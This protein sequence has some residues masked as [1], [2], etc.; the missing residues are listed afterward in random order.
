ML[1]KLQVKIRQIRTLA[2]LTPFDTGTEEGRSNERHRLILLSAVSSALAKV[3]SVATA[4]ISI[5]LTLHYLGT[6][7]F[8]LWMTISSVIA[9]L[10]FADLGIGNGLLNS[11]AEANGRDDIDA[12]KRYIS[13]AFAI[14]SAI[15]LA[16]LLVFFV[17]NPYVSWPGFFNV[18]SALASQEAD[19][20]VSIFML[21]FALN[22]PAGV[23]QR[24]QMALQ[25]SFVAN[26]WLIAG[27]LLGLVTVL[28]VIYFKLGL[29]WLVGGMFGAPILVAIL[30]S[31]FFFSK[32]RPD[33]RPQIGS[34]NR[35]AMNKVAHTGFL[36]LV[37]QVTVSLVFASDNIMISRILGAEAVTQFAIPD[38]LFS[39]IPV[40][41]GMIL[42]P[43]WPAYGEAISRGDGKWIKKIFV[44]S[45]ILALGFATIASL[46]FIVLGNSIL[47]AWVGHEVNAPIVLL[48]GMA[49][50]RIAEASG[51]SVSMLLNGANVV[52]FQVFS[53]LLLFIVAIPLKVYL[54]QNIGIAGAVMGTFVSYLLCVLI[55]Y[56]LLVPKILKRLAG[57]VIFPKII[58]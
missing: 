45:L 33:I 16:I 29:P 4:L 26:L 20:A 22:I 34:V 54:I 42:M 7:R 23:V 12:I 35:M 25:M 10:S 43:L 19:S 40:F 58:D 28:A 41:L 50:W 18:K 21:C 1:F 30:N 48:I 56:T 17:I 8:G 6:E 36:F 39:F 13:S 32:L 15:A 24:A 3:V 11:V 57:D 9:M 55:P 51:H 37:L 38:K 53:C 31:L 2:R 52:K 44:R 46:I 5:P 47:S 27:S 14:L 49:M